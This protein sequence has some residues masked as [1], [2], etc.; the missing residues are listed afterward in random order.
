MNFFATVFGGGDAAG[1]SPLGNDNRGGSLPQRSPFDRLSVVLG[2][3]SPFD[4]DL[5]AGE[6]PFAGR[7]SGSDLP[8]GGN[9][10]AADNLFTLFGGGSSPLRTGASG[11]PFAGGNPSTGGS[12]NPSIPDDLLQQSPFAPLQ[13]VQELIN[14]A[15]AIDPENPPVGN[16]NRDEGNRNATIGNGNQNFGNENATI[17]NGNWLF[18]DQ[19]ATIGNGNWGFSGD[20]VTLGNGNWYWDFGRNNT[21]LGNGNWHFGS[22]NATIGNGNWDFGSNNTIIGNGNWVFTSGNTVV[23]NGNWLLDAETGSLSVADLLSGRAGNDAGSS[24]S[25]PLSFAVDDL[26]NALVGRVGSDLET[27]AG[28]LDADASQTL[29][30]LILSQGTDAPGGSLA[31]SPELEQLFAVLRE[32]ET[33][34]GATVGNGALP[35]N[36]PGQTPEAVPEPAATASLVILGVGLLLW[37][38]YRRG[39][40]SLSGRIQPGSGPLNPLGV[41]E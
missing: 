14:A 34:G 23:G 39:L 37:K 16:G 29:E 36:G 30:Q 12:N 21:T 24:E 2:D 5:P 35:A 10:F 9:P 6:N 20:N 28:D 13:E 17:G 38:G 25:S 1:S 31:G 19:N 27:L 11:N 40:Q 4:A 3:R 32:L 41:R 7:G 18:G 26:V 22:D 33:D 8:S 15:P